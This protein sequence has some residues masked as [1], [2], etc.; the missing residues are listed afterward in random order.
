MPVL[1]SE[2]RNHLDTSKQRIERPEVRQVSLGKRLLQQQSQRT[3]EK[4]ALRASKS[5]SV[6][7]SAKLPRF[8]RSHSVLL[9]FRETQPGSAKETEPLA[10]YEHRY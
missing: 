9:M 10:G 7:N 8:A 4:L 2:K 1:Q 5:C 6:A 3:L